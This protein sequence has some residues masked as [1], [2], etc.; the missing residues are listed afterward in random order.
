MGV[1]YLVRHAQ[2]SFGTADYD[3]L[4]PIGFTQAELLGAYF[5]RRKIRFDAV[6]TGTLR[7]HAE[8]AQAIAAGEPHR[9]APPAQCLPGLDEYNPEAL[10]MAFTGMLP[11]PGAAAVGRD[12][13]V[14][15]EHFR[16]LR[17]ALMAWASD[18]IQPQG[19]PAWQAFQDAAVAA[20]V[21]A[22]GQFADGNV[23]VVSSGGPIAAI[24]AAA[25]R[26]PPESAVELNLRIRNSSVT[27]FAM[28]ARRHQL[29]SFNAL[30]HLD[31][32]SDPGLTTYA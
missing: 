6:Y 11:A 31:A 29:V 16:L 1:I 23:L 4:S 10:L 21:E 17:D 8:T 32:Q 20:L 12:S 30:P 18:R 28:S 14:V 5:A 2:A 13:A 9:S 15:R 25:L 7:R 27:E 19:M 26:A 24:V 3:R 22:R